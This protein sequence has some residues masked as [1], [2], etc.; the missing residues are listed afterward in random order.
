MDCPEDG[1]VLQETDSHG[2]KIHEC[3]ECRGR[4][5]DRDELKRAIESTD[6]DLR[7]L[8]FDPFAGDAK[9]PQAGQG[10]RLCPRDVIPMGVI[11]Y[12][13]S[14]VRIDKCS[15]CHGIWLSSQEFERIIRHLEREVNSETAAQFEVEA[16]RRL[17]QVFTGHEGPISELRDLF[18]VLH[19]LRTRWAVEHPGLSETL[20]AISLGSPLK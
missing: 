2:V 17:G 1:A 10:A 12:E 16:A 20:D 9:E 4:W 18:S 13:K 8:D 15:K 19:L 11:P 3:P 7:W 14:R 6:E 5:F